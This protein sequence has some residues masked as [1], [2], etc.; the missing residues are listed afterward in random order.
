MAITDYISS[1]MDKNKVVDE[2]K[3]VCK[4]FFTIMLPNQ[5]F[6]L[7]LQLCAQDSTKPH[8]GIACL[9]FI[10]SQMT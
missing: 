5:K 1:Q 7:S 10:L 8:I 6:D 3:N 2:L 4:T 9:K